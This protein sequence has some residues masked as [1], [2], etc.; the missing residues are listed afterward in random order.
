MPEKSTSKKGRGRPRKDS[1]VTVEFILDQAAAKYL[2]ALGK[3]NG[4]GD[5]VHAVCKALIMSRY[6]EMQASLFHEKA[7]P[8]ADI[9]GDEPNF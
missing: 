6:I 4:W 5:S 3:R 7:M 9:D 1:P 8:S 2:T